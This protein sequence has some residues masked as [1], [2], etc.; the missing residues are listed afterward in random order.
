MQKQ[1]LVI[2]L[3]AILVAVFALTN[4]EVMAVRLFFW[5]YE[6]SGSLVI[7]ISVALGAVLVFLLNTVGWIKGKLTVKDLKSEL[8]KTKKQLEDVLQTNQTYQQEIENL[9]AEL[10]MAIQANQVE[11]T[12]Q[13][14]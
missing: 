4:A 1:V 2:L 9:K 14:Q 5:T 13:E 3:V 10:N 11:Q 8:D 7:L 6:L 12:Q